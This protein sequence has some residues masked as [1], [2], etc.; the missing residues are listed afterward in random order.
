M[1]HHVALFAI[2]NHVVRG[3]V[4]FNEVQIVPSRHGNAESREAIR[5]TGLVA[6]RRAVAARR[7]EVISFSI[8]DG[9]IMVGLGRGAESSCVAFSLVIEIF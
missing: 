3:T 7:L 8:F 9:Y 2:E 6:R 4:D 5:T 1:S